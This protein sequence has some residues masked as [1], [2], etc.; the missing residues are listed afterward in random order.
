MSGKG[1]KERMRDYYDALRTERWQGTGRFQGAQSG[2]QI[3]LRKTAL[4]SAVYLTKQ[5]RTTEPRLLTTGR[6]AVA[7]VLNTTKIG[8]VLNTGL[9]VLRAGK[10]FGVGIQ[11]NTYPDLPLDNPLKR[12]T[13]IFSG[14][15]DSKS[16]LKKYGYHC[17]YME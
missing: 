6:Y 3:H 15:S 9:N 17:T 5:F 12:V 2:R 10:T 7:P 1:Q 14:P 11:N 4:L 8:K 13:N 16:I